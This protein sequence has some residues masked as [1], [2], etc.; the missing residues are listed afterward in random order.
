MLPEISS[1]ASVSRSILKGCQLRQK[2]RDLRLGLGFGLDLGL[3]AA[4]AL[5][6][7]CLGSS[8]APNSTPS[9]TL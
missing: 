1:F 7:E 8:A 3:G 5:Q 4:S 9:E 6:H 2:A